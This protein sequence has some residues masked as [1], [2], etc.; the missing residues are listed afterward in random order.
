MRVAL[1]I[2]LLWSD[3]L[4]RGNV[5]FAYVALRPA[6]AR[7]LEPLSVYPFGERRSVDSS[8]GYGFR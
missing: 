7:L 1:L 4:G 6:A 5:S 3:H 8:R 2:H